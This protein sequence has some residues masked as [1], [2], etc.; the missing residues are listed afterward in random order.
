MLAQVK[1][2]PH[3][4]QYQHCCH[5]AGSKRIFHL[6]LDHHPCHRGFA[7]PSQVPS[8]NTIPLSLPLRRLQECDTFFWFIILATEVL[9]AQVKSLPHPTTIPLPLPLRRLQESFQVFCGYCPCRIGFARP[10]HVPPT[11]LQS[12]IVLFLK[13]CLTIVIARTAQ[14]AIL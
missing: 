6:F 10:S 12:L 5:C 11:Q 14:T 13:A 9:L 8:P 2:L 4:T 1:S 3:Q 7:C